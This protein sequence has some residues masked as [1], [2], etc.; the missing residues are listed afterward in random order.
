MSDI[1]TERKRRNRERMR[2]MRSF[3]TYREYERALLFKR[4]S[5]LVDDIDR[6]R[7][8][9]PEEDRVKSPKLD[10]MY[11]AADSMILHLRR[12]RV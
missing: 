12:L 5:L 4:F 3:P 6:Y 9:L 10:A 2:L 8:Q 11:V 1:P 7:S